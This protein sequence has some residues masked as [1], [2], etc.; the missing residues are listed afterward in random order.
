M[1]DGWLTQDSLQTQ[2]LE[3]HQKKILQLRETLEEVQ[4]R[5]EK[6]GPAIED[7]LQSDEYL[8]L[9]RKA[10]RIWGAADTEEKRRYVA[11]IVTNSAGTRLTDILG[12]EYK[13]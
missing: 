5:F 3:E 6:L 12:W 2:W 13:P 9:V 1:D 11:N 4:A 8:G 7:R 10:F